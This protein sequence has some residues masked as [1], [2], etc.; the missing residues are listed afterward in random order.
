M[1]SQRDLDLRR[2]EVYRR[3]LRGFSVNEIAQSLGVSGKTVKRD[4]SWLRKR[5]K[6]WYHYHRGL[7][8]RL[9]DA[10]GEAVD[11]REEQVKEG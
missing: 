10:L 11:R 7:I 3:K 6:Q 5:N 2:A 4:L 8:L 9:E 1:T